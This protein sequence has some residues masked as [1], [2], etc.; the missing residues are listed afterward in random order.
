[1]RGARPLP[2]AAGL[3]G[4]DAWCG[5]SARYQAESSTIQDHRETRSPPSTSG[6]DCVRAM[7]LQR[8][9]SRFR[10]HSLQ[11]TSGPAASLDVSLKNRLNLQSRH[12]PEQLARRFFKLACSGGFRMHEP[13]SPHLEPLWI[14][15]SASTGVDIQSNDLQTSGMDHCCI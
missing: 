12:V 2:G 7:P 6:T 4:P 8:C 10:A 13:E 1:M 9:L 3:P 5:R 14:K 11:P 15:M